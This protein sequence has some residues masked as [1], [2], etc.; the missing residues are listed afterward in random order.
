MGIRMGVPVV[1]VD[2]RNIVRD[3][4]LCALAGEAPSFRP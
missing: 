1:L 2:V 3:G 4:D